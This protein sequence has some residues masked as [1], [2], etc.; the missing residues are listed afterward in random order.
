MREGERKQGRDAG[1]QLGQMGGR[2]H[3]PLRNGLREEDAEVKS[4]QAEFGVGHP[5]QEAK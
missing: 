3:P 5:R 2:W 1:L 4:G